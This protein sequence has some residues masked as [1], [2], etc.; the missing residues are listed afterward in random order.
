MEKVHVESIEIP[1]TQH[2]NLRCYGCDHASPLLPE[3]FASLDDYRR[4]LN[5]LSKSL[6]ADEFRFVG[7][8]PLLHPQLF[9]FAQMVREA[10]VVDRIILITNGVLIHRMDERMWDAI[11]G[12]WFSVYPGVKY[13]VDFDLIRSKAKERDLKIWIKEETDF[14][15]SLLNT[16][17]ESKEVLDIVYKTCGMAG[18]CNTVYE[19]RFY[20]CSPA[21]LM[22]ARIEKLKLAPIH[23]KQNDSVAI[24]EESDLKAAL[25]SFLNSSEPLK[26]C[27]MCM[28]DTGFSQTHRQL[29]NNGI[30]AWLAE[31]HSGV[32]RALTELVEKGTEGEYKFRLSD[33]DFMDKEKRKQE[34]Y[35]RTG[36]SDWY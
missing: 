15:L 13:K 24:H 18:D 10:E 17:I 14:N 25:E 23:A 20:K 7:G 3:K 21:P 5:V 36:E 33:P 4:D 8:E 16:P 9:E 31:D 32:V 27:S 22:D 30:A 26:S 2:C 28:G 35:G 19:G 34:F 6:H 11:D 12:L 1:M 29:D